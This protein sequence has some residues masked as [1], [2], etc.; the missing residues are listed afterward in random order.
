VGVDDKYLPI[1]VSNSDPE[2]FYFKVTGPD[3]FCEWRLAINWTSRG[4]SGTTVV[5]QSFGPVKSDT[6]EYK[7]RT[8][9]SLSDG[10]WLKM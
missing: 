5:G 2:V 1:K 4:R 8:L 9:Y 10:E 6:A 7:E 3:C